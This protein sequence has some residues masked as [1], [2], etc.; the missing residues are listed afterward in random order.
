VGIATEIASTSIEVVDWAL[1]TA[2]KA[3]IAV[4]KVVRILEDRSKI[5]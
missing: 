4:E 1:A 3:A 2:T 5:E